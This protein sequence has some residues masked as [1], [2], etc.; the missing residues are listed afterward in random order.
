MGSKSRGTAVEGNK[1]VVEE[2]NKSLIW[3]DK[4]AC[5]PRAAVNSWP[6][7]G[8]V[9]RALAIDERREVHAV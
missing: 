5:A 1:R 8:S 7:T 9:W 2:D 4:V 6:H 3:F